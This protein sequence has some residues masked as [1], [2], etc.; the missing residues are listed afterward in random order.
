M[1]YSQGPPEEAGVFL[2]VELLV[3]VGVAGGGRGAVLM[4][5]ILGLEWK[6]GWE[7]SGGAGGA[8][9]GMRAVA[10]GRK[11]RMGALVDGD[12]Q[13]VHFGLLWK[14]RDGMKKMRKAE[15]WSS[16]WSMSLSQADISHLWDARSISSQLV[17]HF[18]LCPQLFANS[19]I[20]KTYSTQLNMT[21]CS[22]VSVDNNVH[23]YSGPWNSS[24]AFGRNSPTH[25]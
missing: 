19:S 24:S 6:A 22:I 15:L 8:E 25:I 13:Q 10:N 20:C 14:L 23:N 7:D 5:V 9:H 12:W 3:L 17:L 21:T 11:M 2:S 18:N 4:P 16:R 1:E